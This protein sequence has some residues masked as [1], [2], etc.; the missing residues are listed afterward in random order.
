MLQGLGIST[1]VDLEA[2]ATAS[3]WLGEQLD[4][5]LPSETSSAVLGR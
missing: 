2:V 5:P 1:G 4:I 3:Q